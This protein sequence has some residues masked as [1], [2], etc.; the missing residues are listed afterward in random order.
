[1]GLE[2]SK[3]VLDDKRTGSR[4]HLKN[5]FPPRLGKHGSSGVLIGRLTVEGEGPRT[6]KRLRKQFGNHAVRVDWDRDGTDARRTSNGE[7]PRVGG[8]FE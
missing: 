6:R 3:I 4:G 5:L 7:C 2:P 1:M 8:G